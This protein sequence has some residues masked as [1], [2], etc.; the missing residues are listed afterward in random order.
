MFIIHNLNNI[1]KLIFENMSHVKMQG[2]R[3]GY[4]IHT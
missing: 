3:K 2:N 4:I 1:A